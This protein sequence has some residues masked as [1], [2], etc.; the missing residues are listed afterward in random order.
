MTDKSIEPSSLQTVFIF[1][2]LGPE[3]Q[4]CEIHDYYSPFTMR[5]NSVYWGAS[6]WWQMA[7]FFHTNCCCSELGS[8]QHRSRTPLYPPALISVLIWWENS[9]PPQKWE[10]GTGAAAAFLT[11]TPS[12]PLEQCCG[13][14]VGVDEDSREDRGWEV[15]L[16]QP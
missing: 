10:T 1:H 16:E 6:V 15:M 13:A 4:L 2:L 5:L 9:L 11:A 3:K 8:A 7:W 14:G 12:S